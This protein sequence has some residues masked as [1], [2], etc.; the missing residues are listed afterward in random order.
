MRSSPT[1]GVSTRPYLRFMDAM[2]A[3]SGATD[4]GGPVGDRRPR[5]AAAAARSTGAGV[6]RRL[7]DVAAC[8]PVAIITAIA[9]RVLGWSVARCAL[10]AVVID[11]TLPALA[12]RNTTAPARFLVIWTHACRFRRRWPDNLLGAGTA[13]QREVSLRPSGPRTDDLSLRSGDVRPRHGLRALPE[14]ARFPQRIQGT[15]VAWALRVGP[16]DDPSDIGRRLRGLRLVD[17]RILSADLER[18]ADEGGEW[19]VV[20]DFDVEPPSWGLSVVDRH[21]LFLSIGSD[22]IGLHRQQEG[23]SNGNG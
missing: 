22:S 10:V 5:S 18:R 16:V 4:G 7:V 6:I 19:L 8:H 21:R 3:L 12:G 14:L 23:G 2:S 11:Q 17:P 13:L 9:M 20:V 15:T 1:L